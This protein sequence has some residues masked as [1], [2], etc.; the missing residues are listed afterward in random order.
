[1]YLSK[2]YEVSR[3]VV[4]EVLRG[5][6]GNWGSN[7]I[8]YVLWLCIFQ[9]LR[10]ITGFNI[11]THIISYFFIFVSFNYSYLHFFNI[12]LHSDF[13]SYSSFETWCCAPSIFFI[14]VVIIKWSTTKFLPIVFAC[15]TNKGWGLRF[16]K[17][18][19]GMRIYQWREMYMLV[20]ERFL[21]CLMLLSTLLRYWLHLF[22]YIIKRT[23]FSDIK[24]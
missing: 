13:V 14:V 19:C 3:W 8:N 7:L 18:K 12:Y 23:I 15:V 10:D 9:N 11:W 22:L 6:S 16:R 21:R 24:L 17:L 4:V 1:M 5:Y 2:I 20:A